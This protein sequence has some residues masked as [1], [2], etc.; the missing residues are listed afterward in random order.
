MTKE[1][2]DVIVNSAKPDLKHV[3]N[4]GLYLIKEGGPEIQEESDELIRKFH[5]SIPIGNVVA[6][7]AGKLPFKKIIHAVGHDWP[8]HPGLISIK[9][10]QFIA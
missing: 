3:G 5:S 6:T 8:T 1:T 4:L 10:E 7:N 2:T 9:L